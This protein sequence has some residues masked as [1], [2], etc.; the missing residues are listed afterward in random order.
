MKKKDDCEIQVA[1]L[2]PSVLEKGFLALIASF[3]LPF[4]PIAVAA[5]AS[6]SPEYR[7]VGTHEEIP[8]GTHRGIGHW[9]IDLRYPQFTNTANRP[10]LSEINHTIT[11]LI[12]SYRCPTAGDL[13]FDAKVVHI[14]AETI[15]LTYDVM[16]MCE[17]MPHLEYME[18]EITI[19]LRTNEIMRHH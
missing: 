16:W 17:S 9:Q 10:D 8:A 14:D 12:E 6:G 3:I 4:H 7:Y 5:E 11:A 1:G 18:R 2:G 13:S 15:S 19:D